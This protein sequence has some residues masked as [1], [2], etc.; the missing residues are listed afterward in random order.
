M[1]LKSVARW[2]DD[3]GILLPSSAPPWMNGNWR[4]V[5][6]LLA[7]LLADSLAQ[8]K[9]SFGLD[10]STTFEVSFNTMREMSEEVLGIPLMVIEADLFPPSPSSRFALLAAVI[11]I[12]SS[13]AL[14]PK[15]LEKL[16]APKLSFEMENEEAGNRMSVNC[17]VCSQRT[18]LIERVIAQKV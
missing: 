9:Q 4:A 8:R 18:F 15:T 10:D 6:T 16:V 14:E 11:C 3:T 1:S 12:R 5:M 13:T 7:R 2:F 17:I